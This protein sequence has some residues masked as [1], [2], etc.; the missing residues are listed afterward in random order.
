MN[1]PESSSDDS[2][3]PDVLPS[4]DHQWSQ[5]LALIDSDHQEVGG[6]QAEPLTHEQQNQ[7]RDFFRN[8]LDAKA[9]Q[10]ALELMASNSTALEFLASLLKR[11]SPADSGE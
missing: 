9:K 5:L 2:L 4:V 1:I 7:L 3:C 8:H 6:R 11:D 10:E